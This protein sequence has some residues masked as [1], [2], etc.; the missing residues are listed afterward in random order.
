M[1]KS[2]GVRISRLCRISSFRHPAHQRCSHWTSTI[3]API[4]SYVSTSHDPFLN[5]SIE[6]HLLQH[7]GPDSAVLFIYRNRDCVV[8]GRNQNPWLELN[9][10]ECLKPRNKEGPISVVRR[11]SGGG[12]VFHD[13]GNVN[14]TVIS[15]SKSFTR[16][17][18]AEMIVRALRSER[19]AV[20]RARVNERHDI[21]LDQG[22]E[23]RDDVNQ[24]STHET[25]W[26]SHDAPPPLK[27]S[28]SAYKLTRRRALHHGTCLLNTEKLQE[29][30]NFLRSLARAHI[31]A[32]GVESVSS[33]VGNVNVSYEDF[34]QAT[35]TEFAAMYD[36][37]ASGLKH[38]GVGEE[39]RDN[40]QVQDGVKELQTLEWT[41]GQTPQFMFTT[42]LSSISAQSQV[43]VNH[44]QRRQDLSLV[45]NVRHGQIADAGLEYA[46]SETQ[47]ESKID[48][49][50][51][52][53]VSLYGARKWENIIQDAAAHRS[54]RQLE[55]LVSDLQRL[56]PIVP[57]L[58]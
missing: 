20:E 16:D 33:P 39:A 27:C 58:S 36:G 55:V 49:G 28:G 51:L 3:S 1:L 29:M 45:L 53:G 38:V 13:L 34:V 21:V 31:K 15:P 44:H 48:A 6:H 57:E 5:L 37:E 14:W 4:Q 7:S 10:Q 12:C 8:F 18:H 25:K 2:H 41:Y 50:K 23:E 32:R 42:H 35:Q 40:T 46:P 56:L 26:T 43:P 54:P 52:Q 19:C 11:R 9:L 47:H 17:K 30:G 22:E 24:Q